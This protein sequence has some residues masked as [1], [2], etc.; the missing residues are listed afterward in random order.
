MKTVRKIKEVGVQIV[1]FLCMKN[2]ENSPNF[3]EKYTLIQK[4]GY[5]FLRCII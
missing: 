4:E 2:N 5:L 3:A 1:H